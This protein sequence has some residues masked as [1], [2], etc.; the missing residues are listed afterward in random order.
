[1][2]LKLGGNSLW[3]PTL[4]PIPNHENRTSSSPSSLSSTSDSNSN[5][6]MLPSSRI[7][8]ECE[9]L[10]CGTLP[11]HGADRR[12]VVRI[13]LVNRVLERLRESLQSGLLVGGDVVVK[14]P[15]LAPCADVVGS[16]RRE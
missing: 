14:N 8:D 4:T 7:D 5:D 3:I 10:R 1:V 15:L 12:A 16:L 11:T 13:L 6:I 2:T 9:P